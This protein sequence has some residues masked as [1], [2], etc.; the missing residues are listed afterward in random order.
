MLGLGCW[1]P[2]MVLQFFGEVDHNGG[3]TKLALTSKSIR[4]RLRI[5]IYPWNEMVI[6]ASLEY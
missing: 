2:D 6:G 5:S 1:T 4:S 3:P